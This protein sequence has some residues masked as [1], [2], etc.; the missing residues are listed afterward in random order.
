MTQEGC[1]FYL[2]QPQG[3]SKE[4]LLKIKAEKA[5]KTGKKSTQAVLIGS[6]DAVSDEDV[7]IGDTG[8]T[9]HMTNNI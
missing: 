5:Q 3:P 4:E 6:E 2:L 9:R 8:A 7:W 1:D